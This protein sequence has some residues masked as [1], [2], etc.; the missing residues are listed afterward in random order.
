MSR[1]TNRFLQFIAALVAFGLAGA[2]LIN[3]TWPTDLAI[4]FGLAW[5]LLLLAT[6]GFIVD[7]KK[8]AKALLFSTLLMWSLAVIGALLI[9]WLAIAGAGHSL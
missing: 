9:A 8:G 7:G 1:D 3:P 4:P 6:I 2:L 5:I